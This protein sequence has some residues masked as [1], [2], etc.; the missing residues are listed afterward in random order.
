MCGTS[1]KRPDVIDR[2][3]LAIKEVS[4]TTQRGSAAFENA[5]RQFKNTNGKTQTEFCKNTSRV[6]KNRLCLLTSLDGY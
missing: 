1:G 3:R 4:V 2:D 5:S 6:C